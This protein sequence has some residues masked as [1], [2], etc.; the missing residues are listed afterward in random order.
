MTPGEAIHAIVRGLGG[1]HFGTNPPDAPYGALYRF[2][3]L[4]QADHCKE[5][6]DVLFLAATGEVCGTGI[7]L[8]AAPTVTPTERISA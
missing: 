5:I 8:I 2:P 1:E 4:A 6:M 3:T 7:L